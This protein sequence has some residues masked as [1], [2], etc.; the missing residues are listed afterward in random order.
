MG[1]QKIDSSKDSGSAA[2]KRRRH[3]PTFK[4]KNFDVDFYYDYD[5]PVVTR[6]QVGRIFCSTTISTGNRTEADCDKN[7]FLTIK[8]QLCRLGRSLITTTT[9]TTMMKTMWM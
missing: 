5:Y 2:Q 3:G 6:S 7:L 8:D 1:N 9:S 4:R